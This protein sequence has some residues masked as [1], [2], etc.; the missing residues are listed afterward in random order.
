MGESLGYFKMQ[1]LRMWDGN[2]KQVLTENAFEAWAA[3]IRFC[4]EIKD[5]KATLQYQKSFVSSLHNAVELIMK[6][7]MLNNNDHRVAN[8][9]KVKSKSDAELLLDYY[10]SPNL[11]VFFNDLSFQQLSRFETIQFSELISIHKKLF[12]DSLAPHESLSVEL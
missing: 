6:Q 4:D 10:K 5:G 12:G 3:A 8:I 2:M 9:R 7:M 11:N 1:L